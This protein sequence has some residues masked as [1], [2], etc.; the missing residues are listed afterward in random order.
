MP[1][2]GSR[3]TISY[4]PLALAVILANNSGTPCIVNWWRVVFLSVIEEHGGLRLSETSR[5]LLRGDEDLTLRRDRYDVQ[6]TRQTRDSVG[7]SG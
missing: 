3:D 4:R 2:S 6:E 5:P 1:G 7:E